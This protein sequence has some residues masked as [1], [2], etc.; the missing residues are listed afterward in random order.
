MWPLPTVVA[1]I[2]APVEIGKMQPV[3]SKHSPHKCFM[4]PLDHGS[5]RRDS[6]RRGYADECQ[7]S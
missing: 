2:G 6:V 1:G 4:Q 3:S 5:R 7:V